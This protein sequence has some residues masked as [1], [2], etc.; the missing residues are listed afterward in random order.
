MLC[1]I[2]LCILPLVIFLK[3]PAAQKHF[4]LD[5]HLVLVKDV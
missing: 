4:E 3:P 5:V 2:I 1:G